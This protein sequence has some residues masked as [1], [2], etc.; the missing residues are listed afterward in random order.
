MLYFAFVIRV[1]LRIARCAY[2]IRTCF[3]TRHCL[4]TSKFCLCR[5]C[6][7]NDAIKMHALVRRPKRRANTITFHTWQSRI[8]MAKMKEKRKRACMH[9]AMKL[10]PRPNWT[11]TN[12]KFSDEIIWL[13]AWFVNVCFCKGCGNLQQKL[14][15]TE[16]NFNFPSKNHLYLSFA[17][18]HAIIA[19]HQSPHA[20]REKERFC[21]RKWPSIWNELN[22]KLYGNCGAHACSCSGDH[23]AVVMAALVGR[24]FCLDVIRHNLLR[25]TRFRSPPKW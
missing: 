15:S 10:K 8:K 25:N 6:D 14:K 18:P 17:W 20:G 3:C 19:P 9:F 23:R 13:F 22:R 7:W 11:L 16:E 24:G 21:R 5:W 12:Y 1:P 2:D 4:R